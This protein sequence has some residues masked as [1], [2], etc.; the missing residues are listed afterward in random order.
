MNPKTAHQC[1]AV[2]VLQLLGHSLPCAFR[3]AVDRAGC[4]CGCMLRLHPELWELP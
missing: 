2:L 3:I 4:H 1:A